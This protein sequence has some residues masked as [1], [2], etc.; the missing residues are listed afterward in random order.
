MA[1]ISQLKVGSTTYDIKAELLAPIS[2]TTST[3][4]SN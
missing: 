3:S 1:Y 2:S 4:V